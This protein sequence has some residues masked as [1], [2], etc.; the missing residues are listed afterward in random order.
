MNKQTVKPPKLPPYLMVCGIPYY[1]SYEDDT[2]QA[3]DLIS[4]S[5]TESQS[6]S[7]SEKI[8]FATQCRTLCNE[9]AWQML[10]SGGLSNDECTTYSHAVGI[11]LHNFLTSNTFEWVQDITSDTP[12]TVNINGAVYSVY[13]DRDEHLDDLGLAGEIQYDNLTILLYSTL[14][15]VAKR[16]IL[17][18]EIAHGIL[19]ESSCK[20]H[21]DE[22]LIAPLGYF[23]YMLLRDNDFE[24]MRG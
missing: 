1:I 10:N 23:L 21:N 18:H 2:L 12:A 8:P 22:T 11:A 4:K 24:F 19:Y 15:A 17:C 6:I 5:A 13:A 9:V 16:V 7:V 3:A 20:Q 14:A